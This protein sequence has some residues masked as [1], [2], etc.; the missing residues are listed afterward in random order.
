MTI[1]LRAVAE[2]QIFSDDAHGFITHVLD[3][4]VRDGKILNYKLDGLR[5]PTWTGVYLAQ[6]TVDLRFND[7]KEVDPQTAKVKVTALLNEVIGDTDVDVRW[8]YAEYDAPTEERSA[9]QALADLTCAGCGRSN[10]DTEAS[11]DSKGYC[12]DCTSAPHLTVV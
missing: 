8:V 3:K 12:V 6:F 4:G 9:A 11:P 1:H 5:P 2:Q 10:L 7:Y